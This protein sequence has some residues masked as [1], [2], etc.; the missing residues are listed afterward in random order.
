MQPNPSPAPMQPTPPPA[1]RLGLF[2]TT[3][4]YAIGL[5]YQSAGS[6]PDI[7]QSS[8]G[9]YLDELDDLN[10]KVVEA[11]K[12]NALLVDLMA[13]SRRDA[14][15][16]L[17]TDVMAGLQSLNGRQ[18]GKYTGSIGGVGAYAGIVDVLNGTRLTLN[19]WPRAAT[20]ATMYIKRIGLLLAGNATVPIQIST[21]AAPITVVATADT[22]S[23]YTFPTP[24]RIQLSANAGTSDAGGGIGGDCIGCNGNASDYAGGYSGDYANPRFVGISFSYTVNGFM[25]RNNTTSCGCTAMDSRLAEFFNGVLKQPAYG[26]LLDVEIGESEA[27]VLVDGFATSEPVARV[28]AYATRFKAA[29]LLIERIINTQTINRYT[30]LDQQ[31]LWG[32]RNEFRKQ[33]QDRINWLISPDGLRVKPN[34]D[35][36]ERSIHMGR[37][38]L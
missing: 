2:A 14:Y 19:L 32:K 26:L 28:V 35:N 22:P 25:V 8:S 36:L 23:Y 12:P 5:S 31:F 30:T 13:A 29:E 9:L 11:A 15:E 18:L 6:T 34:P 16:Q 38:L 24:L 21:E 10:L 3:Y 37:I 7:N 17:D 1:R 20:G 33:Y 27:Q 4:P